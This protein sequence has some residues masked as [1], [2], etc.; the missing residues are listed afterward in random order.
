[1][2][3]TL[4]R[5]LWA[6]TAIVLMMCSGGWR[7]A[8]GQATRQGGLER[9]A[10]TLALAPPQPGGQIRAVVIGID[11][12]KNQR[13]APTLSGAVADARDLEQA[14][15]RA[16]VVDLTALIDSQATRGAVLRTLEGVARRTRREDLVILTFAGHGNQGRERIAGSEPDHLDEYFV[17]WGFATTGPGARE[18]ILDDE[19][20]IWLREI[21]RGGAQVILLADACFG[22]GM[23]KAVDPRVTPLSVR[24]I[25]RFDQPELATAGMHETEFVLQQLAGTSI[26]DKDNA[27]RN[28]LNLTF[29]AAVDDGTMAPEIDVAGEVTPR[30]AASYALARALEGAADAEGN[31][32]GNTT[33]RELFAFVNKHIRIM[34][35][36]RQSPVVEPRTVQTADAV[37]FRVPPTKPISVAMVGGPGPLTGAGSAAAHPTARTVIRDTRTG[38]IIDGA[39]TVLAYGQPPGALVTAR[40]RLDAYSMLTGLARGRAIEVNIEPANRDLRLGEPFRLNIAGLYGRYVLLL[41]LAGD[42]TVQYLFPKGRVDPFRIEDVLTQAMQ[43]AEPPGAD[44]LVVIATDRRRIGLEIALAGLDQKAAP[45]ALV[46]ALSTYLEPNDKVGLVTYTTLPP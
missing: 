3:R 25:P 42:G 45:L 14:F 36:D 31:G 7:W 27:T 24:A 33:R 10:P 38:D 15:R 8:A 4:I 1:M 34:S 22:G 23:T 44:T 11:N 13:I 21:A 9:A 29:I 6:L 20:F 30:G 18:R 46:Q 35:G 32:D 16:G 26:P 19:I 37:L 41:N 43:A 5:R 39:G 12:Y 28:L 2:A 17:M 40:E